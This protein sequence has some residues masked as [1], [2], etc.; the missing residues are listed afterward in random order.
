MKTKTTHGGCGIVTTEYAVLRLDDYG[1]VSDVL[2][3]GGLRKA[4][5]EAAYYRAEGE[6]V[7]IE[8]QTRRRPAHLFATPD[9]FDSIKG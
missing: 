6:L 3:C 4:R 9:Q 1:D 8:K 2:H 7:I 5:K